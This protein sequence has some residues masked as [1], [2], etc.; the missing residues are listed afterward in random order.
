MYEPVWWNVC[1][2]THVHVCFCLPC[3]F[4]ISTFLSHHFISWECLCVSDT[5]SVINWTTSL[6][7]TVTHTQLALLFVLLSVEKLKVLSCVSQQIEN[8]RILNVCIYIYIIYIYFLPWRMPCVCRLAPTSSLKHCYIFVLI[9]YFFS[10]H[11]QST[12]ERPADLD[13]ISVNGISQPASQTSIT[14][15]HHKQCNCPRKRGK[16]AEIRAKFTKLGP[17][18]VPLSSLLLANLCSLKKKKEIRLNLI[19]QREI[20]SA[21]AHEQSHDKT[22]RLDF[23]CILDGIL[24]LIKLTFRTVLL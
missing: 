20:S 6:A 2:C 21:W 22:A 23:Y 7:H 17:K 9:C 15:C 13:M 19:Q 12:S 18:A 8:L 1:V 4:F 11:H 5:Q 14:K 3:L 16:S 24:I 10:F